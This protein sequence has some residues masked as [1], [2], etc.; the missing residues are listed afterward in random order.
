[1]NFPTF[2]CQGSIVGFR[3]IWV[4]KIVSLKIFIM[5]LG[6]IIIITPLQRSSVF[7][8]SWKGPLK[9]FKT[10][11]FLEIS[12]RISFF[13]SQRGNFN[14]CYNKALRQILLLTL[15]EFKRINEFLFPL[16]SSEYIW[17]SDDF[18]GDGRYYVGQI[19]LILEAKFVSDSWLVDL[20]VYMLECGRACSLIPSLC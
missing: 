18:R 19:S 4:V 15:S 20:I 8:S 6:I 17:F 14:Y 7:F 2:C 12:N 5:F 1:M 16:K 13:L 11:Y 10:F 9:L 3:S